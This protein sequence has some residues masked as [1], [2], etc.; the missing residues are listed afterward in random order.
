MEDIERQI[1]ADKKIIAEALVAA[2][3]DADEEI[4]QPQGRK[5]TEH[6]AGRPA[7]GSFDPLAGL[8]NFGS[9]N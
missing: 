2:G 8:G 9:V 7:S 4:D 6:I 1:E 3:V 5:V